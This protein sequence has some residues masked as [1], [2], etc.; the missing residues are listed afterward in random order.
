MNELMMECALIQ[1]GWNL[2]LLH[3]P[4]IHWTY[5]RYTMELSPRFLP[6][7]PL[8]RDKPFRSTFSLDV[9]LNMIEARR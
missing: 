4:C 7:R 6:R 1:A 2:D 3:L 9:S 8:P 5:W